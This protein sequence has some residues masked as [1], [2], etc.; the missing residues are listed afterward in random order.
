MGIS[1]Y[2]SHCT[3]AVLGERC[4]CCGLAAS[5]GRFCPG[6]TQDLVARGPGCRFC[7]TP[8]DYPGM[9]CGHCLQR[10]QHYQELLFCHD[11][12]GP[13]AEM[14]KNFKYRG[15]LALAPA[16]GQLLAATLRTIK[17]GRDTATALTA[18]PMHNKRH[19]ERGYN[20]ADLL[21]Q[22]C[23]RY[24]GR[25]L[26]Q[27]LRRTRHTPALEMLDRKS[28]EKAM[29]GAFDCAPV[30]GHWLLVD[31]VFTTGASVN[32]ASLALKRA[33]A[34]TVT[35][36]CLART[37]LRED[38]HHSLLNQGFHGTRDAADD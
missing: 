18:M 33:G 19:R 26:Q 8:M 9:V 20:Q 16:L 38:S 5:P 10:T 36:L 4:G 31:D 34:Q 22:Y 6:C 32:A 3:A 13:L 23:A 2:I 12:G 27:P 1:R 29:R 11:Y 17:S 25:T 21:S 15:D 28:R 35:V 14:I 24:L 7:G 30:S 37:P